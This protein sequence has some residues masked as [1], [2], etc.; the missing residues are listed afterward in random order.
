MHPAPAMDGCTMR[1]R[2]TAAPRARDRR[3]QRPPCA[4]PAGTCVDV[5]DDVSSNRC[6]LDFRSKQENR[7]CSDCC[8]IGRPQLFGGNEI[9]GEHRGRAKRVAKKRHARC[10]AHLFPT[11]FAVLIRPKVPCSK[12]K[13][14]CTICRAYTNR[15][16][17]F[18]SSENYWYWD[19]RPALRN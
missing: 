12:L 3:I 8:G 17:C 11:H 15:E 4:R 2:W 6:D 10:T 19:L 16:K 5:W 13:R 7:N 9:L 14:Q 1:L 18:T